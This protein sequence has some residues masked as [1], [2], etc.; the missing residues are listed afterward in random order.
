LALNILLNG[1][2]GSSPSS[3]DEEEKKLWQKSFYLLIC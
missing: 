1:F 2:D 3:Y